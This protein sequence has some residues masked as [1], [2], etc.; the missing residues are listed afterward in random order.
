MAT[1]TVPLLRTRRQLIEDVAHRARDRGNRR[2]DRREVVRA[3]NDSIYLWSNR[4]FIPYVYTLS[5]GW[6]VGIYEYALPDYISEPLV[7]QRKILTPYLNEEGNNFQFV[8]ADILGYSVD[9]SSDG[10]QSLRVQWNEGV[11]AATNDARILWW[12]ENYPLP[13]TA[14]GE[15][16]ALHAAID[17]DDT[18][19]TLDASVDV[20]RAGYVKVGSEFLQ[21]A[22]TALDTGRTVLQNLVRGVSS[23]AAA[24]SLGDSVEFCM[25][26]PE[27]RLWQV[28]QWQARA[29][30]YDLML[31]ESPAS[32]SEHYQWQMRWNEQRVGEFWRGWVPRPPVIRLSRRS[33]GHMGR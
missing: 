18:T 32:E 6:E 12:G 1:Y 2:W 30:L 19:L 23:T 14:D 11:T 15:D 28:L 27:L 29:N 10:G 26:A 13:D 3:I 16:P 17:A 20:G 9:P 5:G 22:G 8:W 31:S 4:V 24:H 21:Y 25:A 7:P 33:V